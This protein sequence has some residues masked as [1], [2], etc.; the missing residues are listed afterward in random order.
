M[1][2]LQGKGRESVVVLL[3]SKQICKHKRMFSPTSKLF[4]SHFSENC[5]ES[6]VNWVVTIFLNC[7]EGV[8]QKKAYG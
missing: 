1:V 5:D 2:C 8:L 4:G 7:C 3:D 6:E